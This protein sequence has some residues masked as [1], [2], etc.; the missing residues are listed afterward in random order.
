MA[1]NKGLSPA[2]DRLVA[3]HDGRRFISGRL[4]SGRIGGE[5]LP[6]ECFFSIPGSGSHRP[7]GI[8]ASLCAG[9]K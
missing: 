6:T 2:V 7:V 9:N 3:H 5:T 1:S 4:L 8:G